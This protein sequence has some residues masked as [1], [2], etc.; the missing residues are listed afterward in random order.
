MEM[1]ISSKYKKIR[2]YFHIFTAHCFKNFV[3]IRKFLFHWT[4]DLAQ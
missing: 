3:Y 2:I 1:Y 4:A